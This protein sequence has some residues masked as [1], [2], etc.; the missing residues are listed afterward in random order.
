MAIIRFACP[1]GHRDQAVVCLAAS[2]EFFPHPAGK[3]AAAGARMKIIADIDGCSSP[4]RRR[5][6]HTSQ[7]PAPLVIGGAVIPRRQPDHATENTVL[8]LVDSQPA[9]QDR[10]SISQSGGYFSTS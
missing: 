5:R 6:R 8:S 9:D 10:R 4:P 3:V 2:G 7:R 1:P